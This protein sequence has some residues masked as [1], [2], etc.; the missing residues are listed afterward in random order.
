MGLGKRAVR[1]SGRRSGGKSTAD[2]QLCIRG[3]FPN[4]CLPFPEER[5]GWL[6]CTGSVLCLIDLAVV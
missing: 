6:V 4:E 1:G 5:R 3:T 2:R